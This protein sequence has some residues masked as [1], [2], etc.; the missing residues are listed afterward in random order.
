M[1]PRIPASLPTLA[2]VHTFYY[3]HPSACEVVSPCGLEF[4]FLITNDILPLFMYLLAICIP[5]WEKCLFKSSNR[6]PIFN[7]ITSIFIKLQDS[8]IYVGC[9]LLIRYVNV[10]YFLPSCSLS[11]HLL[12]GYHSQHKFFNFNVSQFFLF[13]L[14][15]VIFLLYVRKHGLKKS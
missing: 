5:S 10:K 3:S 2:I 13:F 15:L 8:F 11:F 14:S 6:W 12:D 1:G 9:K 7:C 4:H